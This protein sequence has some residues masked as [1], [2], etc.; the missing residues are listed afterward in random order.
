LQTA[1]GKLGLAGQRLRL[2]ANLRGVR[3]M[4]GDL[5]AHGRKPR[6]GVLARRQFSQRRHRDLMR[7]V[8]FAA[9]GRKT[10]VGFRERR[11]ACGMTVDL[12]LGVGMAFVRRSAHALRR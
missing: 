5:L 3:A 10:R 4:A 6:L 9:I 7:C 1:V 11:V 2:G 12:T 8:G